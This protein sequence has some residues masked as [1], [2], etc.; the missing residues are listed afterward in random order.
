MPNPVLIAED[1]PQGL[2]FF[3]EVTQAEGKAK[4]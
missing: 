3:S 2:D 1:N 4:P